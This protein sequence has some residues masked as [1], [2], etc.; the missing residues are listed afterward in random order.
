MS[1]KSST[2]AQVK[3]GSSNVLPKTTADG[4]VCFLGG[5]FDDWN[6]SVFLPFLRRKKLARV[7]DPARDPRKVYDMPEL[8]GSPSILPPTIARTP[9]T[10]RGRSASTSPLSEASDVSE[11]V[12]PLDGEAIG[13]CAT[14]QVQ[15]RAC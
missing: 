2:G 5:E 12:R 8:P 7:L 9:H 14:G 15:R 4:L 11:D 13:A 1:K 10:R 6:R 3:S